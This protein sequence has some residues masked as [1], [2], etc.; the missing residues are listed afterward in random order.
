MTAQGKATSWD[1]M[2]PEDFDKG[3]PTFLDR[4]RALPADDQAFVLGYVWSEIREALA[5]LA[6]ARLSE[7]GTLFEDGAK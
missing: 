7:Q 3:A 2:L 4:F 5:C 6:E 1:G